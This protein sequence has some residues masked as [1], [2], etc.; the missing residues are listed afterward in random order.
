MVLKPINNTTL[1]TYHEENSFYLKIDLKNKELVL[2]T[3]K[4]NYYGLQ[5]KDRNKETIT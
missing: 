5:F 3:P 1:E 2:G 4:K